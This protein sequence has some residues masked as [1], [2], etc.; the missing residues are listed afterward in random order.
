MED[1]LDTVLDRIASKDDVQGVLVS[2]EQGLCISTRGSANPS[3]APF[4]SAIASYA[5]ELH[6]RSVAGGAN[7]SKSSPTI[8]VEAEG[9]RV[10]IRSQG[11][12][13]LAVYK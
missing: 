13:T 7:D 3:A 6:S 12:Y 8:S 1:A 5:K 11:N 2:D 10:L 9:M 4:I